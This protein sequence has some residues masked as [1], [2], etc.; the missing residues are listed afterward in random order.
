MTGI[1]TRGRVAD[2]GN[3]PVAVIDVGS[4]SVRLV[5]FDGAKRVPIPVFNEK[6]VCGLGRGLDVT[7]RL[8]PEGFSMAVQSLQRFAALTDA[9]GVDDITVFATAAVREAE[10]GPQ[11]VASVARKC[12]LAVRPIPGEEEAR[13][14]AFGVLAAFPGAD[15][16]MVDLGG[17]SVEIVRLRQG[18]I[19]RQ[20]TLAMGPIRSPAAGP[21]AKQTIVRH[22]A[23]LDWLESARGGTFH[24]VGGAWRA[25]ARVHMDHTKYPLLVTH[26]YVIAGAEARDFSEMIANKSAQSL[27]KLPGISKKRVESVPFAA[28]LLK[29]LIEETGVAKVVF[30]ASGV[31]EGCLFDRLPQAVRDQDPL[32][33]ACRDLAW[34]TGRA[35][36][37]GEALYH[38]MTPM[39]PGESEREARLRRAACLLADLEWSEHP[40]YRVEH[41]LLRILRYPLVGVDHAG[42]A[43]MGLAVASRHSRVRKKLH[44]RFLRRLLDDREAGRARV[45]GLAMRLGYTVSGGVISLLEQTALRREDDDL[46]L[47][48]PDHADVLVGDVVQRRFKALAKALRCTPRVD[49]I[50]AAER[51]SA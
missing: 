11:F 4:N 2:G 12:G 15:G 37:D 7:G 24:A 6:V 40:D 48:L 34:M 46:V 5:V 42:R 3:K 35:T 38:W 33:A 20:A 14:S 36:A 44:N 32:I 13:L 1:M 17:A 19:A 8:H 9:M 22:L 21:D 16:L 27:R 29:R 50:K 25:L 51:V 43:Y 28:Y 18:A 41:A 49:Y 47:E 10:D 30:S 39:F 45:T 26:N 23:G 31:R